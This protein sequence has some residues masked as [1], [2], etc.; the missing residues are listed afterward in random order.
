MADSRSTNRGFSLIELLSVVLIIGILAAIAI[1]SYTKYIRKSRL[2]EAVTNLTTIDTYQ[3]TYFSEEDHYT[4][5]GANPAAVPQNAEREVFDADLGDWPELGTP[6]ADNSRLNFQYQAWAEQFGGSPPTFT[7]GIAQLNCLATFTTAVTPGQGTCT[8]N[9]KT[10]TAQQLNIPQASFSNFFFI[11]A[12][13][14]QDGDNNC[15][16]LVKTIDRSDIYREDEL[17]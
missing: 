11:T 9:P 15:S 16:L 2:S 8:V 10:I 7:G 1:P 4:C 12:V 3:E 6:I 13:A 14:D 5:L 17:E